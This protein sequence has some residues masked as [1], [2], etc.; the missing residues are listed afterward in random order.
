MKLA[1]R[2]QITEAFEP[3]YLQAIR[4]TTTDMFTGKIL[5]IFTFLVNTYGKLTDEEML[6]REQ[7]LS[8][9]TYDPAQPVDIIFN[10][11]DRF[12]DLCDISKYALL[13]IKR[14]VQFAYVIF[15][16]L[17]SFFG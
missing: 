14:E 1:L 5:D 13:P 16:K 7:N 17:R 4:N 6:N 15:Q 11:I 10:T 12:S 8:A 3:E 2:N 9:M